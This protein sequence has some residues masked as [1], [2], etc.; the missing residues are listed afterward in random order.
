MI[1][2]GREKERFQTERQ[3]SKGQGN[4]ILVTG[5]EMALRFIV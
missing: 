3:T 1:D 4:N 5:I 2:G